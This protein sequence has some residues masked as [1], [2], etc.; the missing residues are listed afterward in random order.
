MTYDPKE[1]RYGDLLAVFDKRVDMTQVN[2]QGNDVGTQYRTGIYYHSEEQRKEAEA[3][4][5]EKRK[6]GMKVREEA[7]KETWLSWGIRR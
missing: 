2:R 4:M 7:G 5:D 6:K 1:C 3:F